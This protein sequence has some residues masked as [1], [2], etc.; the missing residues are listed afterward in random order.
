MIVMMRPLADGG[1][2]DDEHVDDVDDDG[3][4]YVTL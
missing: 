1:D 3:N 4:Q 2:A